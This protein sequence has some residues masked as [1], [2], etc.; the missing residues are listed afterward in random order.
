MA[1]PELSVIVPDTV[2]VAA[3]PFSRVMPVR[4]NKHALTLQTIVNF[5]EFIYDL[6]SNFRKTKTGGYIEARTGYQII[7]VMWVGQ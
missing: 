7:T 2:A 3:W 6:Q 1:A 4:T 5:L